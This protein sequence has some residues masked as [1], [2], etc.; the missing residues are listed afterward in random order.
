MQK[1]LLKGREKQGGTED[2]YNPKPQMGCSVP[3]LRHWC[4]LI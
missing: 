4:L 1:E 3:L 2:H